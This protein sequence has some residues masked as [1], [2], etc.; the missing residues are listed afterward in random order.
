MIDTVGEEERFGEDRL[1]ATLHG[2][3][4]A[5]DAVARI[6]AA[7][8]DFA[9]GSQADDIAVIAVERLRAAGRVA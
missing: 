7:V 6:E 4:G 2:V 9:H 3:A 1:I 8:R 5:A